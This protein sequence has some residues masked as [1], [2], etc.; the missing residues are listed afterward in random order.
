MAEGRAKKRE[1]A[2]FAGEAEK[3]R[4]ETIELFSF[5]S[6]FHGVTADS[7]YDDVEAGPSERNS[8]GKEG[9]KKKPENKDRVQ[10]NRTKQKHKPMEDQW[11]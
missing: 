10:Q 4:L 1:L 11:W 9:L 2:R 6:F 8:G 7:A 3:T 5:V